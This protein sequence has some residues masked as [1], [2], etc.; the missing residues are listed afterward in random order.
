M[1]IVV[2][3]VLKVYNLL[4]DALL[5]YATRPYLI[6]G[7]KLFLFKLKSFLL[8]EVLHDIAHAKY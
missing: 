3:K 7:L 6:E 1:I 5:C 4:R 2:F 8:Y